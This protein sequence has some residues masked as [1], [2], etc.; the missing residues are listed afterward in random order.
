MFNYREKAHINGP[1][2]IATNTKKEQSLEVFD[3]LCVAFLD[4]GHLHVGNIGSSYNGPV[5]QATHCYAPGAWI[6]VTPAN[7][8]GKTISMKAG[9]N[10]IQVGHLVVK[11]GVSF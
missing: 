8:T 6:S 5:F 7:D 9:K 3:S 10:S 11:D 2:T 1:F 4:D